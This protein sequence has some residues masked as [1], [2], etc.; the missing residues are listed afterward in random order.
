[1]TVAESQLCS[2]CGNDT[3]TVLHFFCHC[4]I[5][6][7]LCMQMQNWLSNILDIPELT[8]KIAVLER[9]PCQ[10]TTDILI[11]HIL[12][13]KKFCIV[14]ENCHTSRPFGIKRLHSLHTEDQTGHHLEKWQANLTL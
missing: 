13:F 8:S 9:Y 5:T 2:L 10:G 7:N 11:N 14:I 4:S 1:M 12:M 3:E 6:Q